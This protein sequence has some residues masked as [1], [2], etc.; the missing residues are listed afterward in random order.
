MRTIQEMAELVARRFNP[1][2]IILFGS[3]ARGQAGENSDVDLMV[4]MD[5]DAP[6]FRRSVPIRLALLEKFNEP[7]DVIVRRPSTYAR[8][9]D[10]PDTVTHEAAQHGLVLYEKRVG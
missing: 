4:V 3:Y 5:S 6:W 1:E 2:K 7:V 8:N 10:T 9:R